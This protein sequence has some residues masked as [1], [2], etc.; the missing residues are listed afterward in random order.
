[1]NHVPFRGSGDVMLAFQQNTI[2]LFADQTPLIRQYGL[3]PV[4]SFSEAR[5]ADFPQ[6]P[7]VRESG[8]D[9]VYS[10]WSGLY[11]PAGTPEPVLARLETACERTMRTAAVTD[12]FA[13]VNQPIRYRARAAF[14]AFTAAESEKFRVLMER[15]GIRAAE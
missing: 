14:A 12:G 13:R 1:M 11:A 8:H 4:A 15:S 7:T 5:L 2:Q 10:I 3:H 6:T 9:I